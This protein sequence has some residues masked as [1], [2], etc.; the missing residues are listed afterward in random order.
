MASLHDDNNRAVFSSVIVVTDRTV[1][2]AQLQSTIAGFDH[3]LGSVET[4]G[5]GKNSQ[6]LRNAI[7][8]GVRIIVTTLQ[9][10]PV[11]Y[12]QVDA[13]NGR[14]YAII[15]DEAH[16]SQ[17][18]SSAMKLKT[19]LA[20][21]RD[22]LQEYAEIEGIEEEKVDP[23]NRLVKEL[24]AH[25][26][27]KNLSFFAFT[28]TPKD[29]TLEMF[30]EQDSTGQF[31]PFHIYSMHQAIEEGFILDVLQNYMTYKTCFKIV[32]ST[33]ENPEVPTSRAS[34]VIKKYQQLHPE[35]I[36]LKAEIIVET[37]MGTTRGKING[38]A[39]MM[40]VTASRP[41][42]VLFFQAIKRFAEEQRYTEVKPM[43]AFSG[44]VTLDEETYTE[45]GLNVRTD[46]S[47]IQESQTKQ[48]FHD[49][50]NILIVAE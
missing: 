2:D 39:K 44:E 31:H 30:G 36:R 24:I 32:N 42:A 20:D 15:C 8:N 19:A 22:A 37:F 41:A 9:K 6:D 27:H 10:F 46:G 40:V 25:G 23:Q 28:A 1:L 48:E 33:P 16:S 43:V 38:K 17:T 12:E 13:A 47:H 14:N 11:I 50:Y 18:G 4:I 7:N 26:K 45:S 35:N 29:T 5:E 3:T 21:L 49:N 34:K